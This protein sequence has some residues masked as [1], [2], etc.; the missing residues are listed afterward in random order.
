MIGQKLLLRSLCCQFSI[1]QVICT[2]IFDVSC[3][4]QI[5]VM[6]YN[7]YGWNA[8]NNNPWKK[9]NLY[10]VIKAFKPDILGLQESTTKFLKDLET[11]SNIGGGYSFGI[12]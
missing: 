1:W 2:F 9:K 10:K 4:L 6:S 11:S 8:I 7:V 12:I 3:W 5:K